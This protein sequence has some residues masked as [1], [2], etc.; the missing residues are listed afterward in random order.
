MKTYE[1]NELPSFFSSAFSEVSPSNPLS[2][3]RVSFANTRTNPI[4]LSHFT[5]NLRK[6]RTFNELFEQIM[7]TI[8]DFSQ[9]SMY[10]SI[11]VR[12]S[13]G[14]KMNDADI[15]LDFKEKSRF[16]ASFSHYIQNRSSEATLSCKAGV[17]NLLG[18]AEK[19]TF[20]YEKALNNSR[21]SE[22]DISLELPFLIFFKDFRRFYKN[23]NFSLNK[24]TNTK[25]NKDNLYE[26][27]LKNTQILRDVSIV[28]GHS[29]GQKYLTK[30]IEEQ[31]ELSFLRVLL[32]KNKDTSWTISS[33]LRTNFLENKHVC[34][35]FLENELLPSHKYSIKYQKTL[36]NSLY[37]TKTRKPKGK[38]TDFAIELAYGDVF[39]AKCEFLHKYHFIFRSLKRVFPKKLA[40]SLRFEHDFSLNLAKSL[41]NSSNLRINDRADAQN[42]RGFS[43]IGPREP[44]F[45]EIQ[46]PLAMSPGYEHVGDLIGSDFIAKTGLKLAIFNFPLLKNA[47]IVPFMHVSGVWIRDFRGNVEGKGGVLKR[48]SDNLRV[49]A[50]LGAFAKVGADTK[51][52]ILYNFAHLRRKGDIPCEF[53]I[54]LSMND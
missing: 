23:R 24:D 52:E 53:Q 27:I 49:S 44:P 3:V 10:K 6:S 15:L 9:I 39:F 11:N 18:F 14:E 51:L 25:E 32:G 47:N 36:Q 34:R 33:N 40:K 16:F 41:R 42:S 26:T 8:T 35:D 7:Q 50:G 46:H 12:L 45:N 38:Y 5:K 20:D 28:A 22:F 1:N 43:E 21:R 29:E 37:E 2:S 4:I 19:F 30:N 48:F 54:R 31:F 17:R 13:P